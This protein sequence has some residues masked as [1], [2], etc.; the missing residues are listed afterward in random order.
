[1]FP[2]GKPDGSVTQEIL[3]WQNHTMRMMYKLVANA[4]R[5]H[6][7]KGSPTDYL[8]FYCL[9]QREVDVPEWSTPETDKEKKLQKTRR[10]PVYVHSKMMITDDEYIIVGSANINQ[11][12]MSG[13][14]D[15]EIAVG[16]FQQAH[17]VENC[18]GRPKG[19][20]HAFRMS[21]WAEHL[22]L[23]ESDFHEPSSL[24]CVRRVNEMA[25]SNLKLYVARMPRKLQGLLLK[26]PISV[27]GDGRLSVLPDW[28]RFP[29]TKASVL[30]SNSILPGQL[31]V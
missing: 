13:N 26:Y 8:N 28:R 10:F 14:R 2:E 29:D 23:L 31:T 15:T 17:T 25:S 20:V 9:G 21:L 30:G 18:A 7:A 3:Y 6:E 22:G 19:K 11:R 27:G 16:A 12:S 4:L 5:E 24:A 1:M